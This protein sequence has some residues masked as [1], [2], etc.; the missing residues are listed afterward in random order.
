MTQRTD[1]LG[2]GIETRASCVIGVP[3]IDYRVRGY[4][5][6]TVRLGTP[7]TLWLHGHGTQL[8]TDRGDLL[9]V[10]APK[11]VDPQRSLF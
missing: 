8:W 3:V 6:A 2:D 4:L 5:V 1:S 9:G 11:A 7:P 10:A